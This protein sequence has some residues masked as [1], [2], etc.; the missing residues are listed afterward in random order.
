MPDSCGMNSALRTRDGSWEDGRILPTLRRNEMDFMVLLSLTEHMITILRLIDRVLPGMP[1]FSQSSVAPPARIGWSDPEI[2]RSVPV[3]RPRTILALASAFIVPL[4]EA[5]AAGLDSAHD[6]KG[7]AATAPVIGWET[8][9]NHFDHSQSSRWHDTAPRITIEGSLAA[10]PPR[11]T[12]VLGHKPAPFYCNRPLTLAN[13]DIT[14]A[15][16]VIHGSSR[17]AADYFQA[18]QSALPSSLDPA[19]DWSRK[20]IVI[21]PHF[22][23]KHHARQGESWWKGDWSAG[24]DSGGLSSYT[25]VDALV[26]RLRSLLFPNLKWIVIT[27]HSAGGQ[28]VQRYAAFTAI[29]Q[30]PLPNAAL[31]K[32]VPANPSSYVYLNEYRFDES[33]Q[34]WV[35]PHGKKSK[36]YNDY[37]YGL[38][39]LDDYAADRGPSWARHH[40]PKQ[41]IEVL[42]GTDDIVA[43]D[44]FD[45]SKEAMWQGDSR[46]ERALLYDAFMD[47]FYPRNRFSVTPIPNAGHDHRQIYASSEAAQALFFPD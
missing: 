38:A 14:R 42:A 24:G 6:P 40:L 16:I 2:R 26:T 33:R 21:A 11:E 3:L 17:N 19:R 23:E 31:V 36:D 22:Q 46:Y 47:R 30:Q 15:I 4:L 35:I 43:N 5:K 27:G 13:P 8:E 37:K 1:A 41:W 29:D 32:F 39:S 18:I 20:T 44:S 7:R 12:L 25:V 45:D 9:F 34:A 28:F 10:I